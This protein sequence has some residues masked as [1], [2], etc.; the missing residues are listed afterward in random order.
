MNLEVVCDV[1]EVADEH[2][3]RLS[4]DRVIAWLTAKVKAVLHFKYPDLDLP[5]WLKAMSGEATLGDA[6]AGP[7]REEQIKALQDADRV[8]G[9]KDR[10]VLAL[11]IVAD[12]LHSS[13]CDKLLAAFH[14]SSSDMNPSAQV[15]FIADWILLQLDQ[16]SS[17][18][19]R[20][21]CLCFRASRLRRA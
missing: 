9:H 5:A 19:P 3:F 2:Y 12:Y 4:D 17:Y 8:R 16:C 6:K 11:A 1:R 14:L 13:W 10:V 18:L 20:F 7:S 21:A 15:S